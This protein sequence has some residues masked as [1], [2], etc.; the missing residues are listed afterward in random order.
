MVVGPL[1]E[2]E[3]LTEGRLKRQAPEIDG[4]LLIN[5]GT[6]APGALIEVEITEAHPYDVVGKVIRVVR[7]PASG[8]RMLPVV[9]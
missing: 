1:A 9:G 6:A 2:M 7:E 5:D 3:L 8:S 4:R